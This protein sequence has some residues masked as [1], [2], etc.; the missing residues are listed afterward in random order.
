MSESAEL[1]TLQVP[2]LVM[3]ENRHAFLTVHIYALC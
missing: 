3:A 1:V 2:V